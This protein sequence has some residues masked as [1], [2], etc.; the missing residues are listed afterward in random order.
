MSTGA[1]SFTWNAVA[2]S[3]AQVGAPVLN[4]ALIVVLARTAGPEVLGTYSILVTAFLVVD[5][6]RLFGLQRLVTREVAAGRA[7]AIEMFRGFLGVADGAGVAAMLALAAYGLAVGAPA[8]AVLCFAAGLPPSARV[9][10]NDALFLARGR[11]D[12]TTRVVVAECSLRM[13]ASL[14]VLWLLGPDLTALAAVYAGARLCAALLG[15]R[16]RAGLLGTADARRD[17]AGAR[18]MAA[19]APAFF[20]VTALPLLLLRADL[21]IVGAIAGA[22]EIGLYGAAARLVSIALMLPDGVMLANFA[23]L[24]RSADPAVR[25]RA[26]RLVC[27]AALA[28]LVPAAAAV[29]WTAGPAARLVYGPGFA[30]AGRFLIWLIWSVPLFI[31]CRAFGDAMVADG[32]ERRLAAIILA[33]VAASVPIYTVLTYH[34]GAAGAAMAYIASLAVLLVLSAAAAGFRPVRTIVRRD[35]PD[36]LSVET[37]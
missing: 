23:H 10:G 28:L 4:A 22:R 5:Q 36:D 16:Y 1:R 6:L 30:D 3:T 27:V 15:R 25:R 11:A 34:A 13:L 12:F 14:G 20:A 21:L 7:G 31:L 19:D 24:A 32:H 37:S 17:W 29:A 8:G 26:V 9:W 2:L 33:T 35:M 18:K